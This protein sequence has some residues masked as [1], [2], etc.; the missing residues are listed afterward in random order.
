MW[1]YLEKGFENEALLGCSINVHK[2][3]LYIIVLNLLQ[4]RRINFS[5]MNSQIPGLKKQE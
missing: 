2:L 5:I 4:I 1:T 3:L